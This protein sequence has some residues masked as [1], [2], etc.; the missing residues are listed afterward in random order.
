MRVI[1]SLG[2]GLFVLTIAG[3]ITALASGATWTKSAYVPAWYVVFLLVPFVLATIVAYV[4]LGDE[5]V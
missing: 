5:D 1:T 4:L 2:F 3:L